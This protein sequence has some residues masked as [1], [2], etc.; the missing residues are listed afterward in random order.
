MIYIKKTVSDDEGKQTLNDRWKSKRLNRANH[1]PELVV[2]LKPRKFVK[3]RK[4][5]NCCYTINIDRKLN[6]GHVLNNKQ[7]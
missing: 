2:L 7:R 3:T 6:K 4:P 1:K 5:I